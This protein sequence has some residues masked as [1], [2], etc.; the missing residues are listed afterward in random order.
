MKKLSA[1]I[2]LMMAF[3]SAFAEGICPPANVDAAYGPFNY[4]D[5]IARANRLPI[6]QKFHFTPNVENLIKGESSSLGGDLDYVLRSF[7]N[8]HRALNSL[9]RLALKQKRNQ[10]ADMHFS[11]DC[12][13]D[14]AIGYVPDDA[15]VHLLY[16]NYLYGIKKYDQSLAQYL[17]A[18]KID[19]E[20]PNILYN[21][22]LLY[23]DQKDYDKALSYAKKAYAAGFPLQGLKQKLEKAGKWQ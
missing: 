10:I 22:G 2:I 17:D 23:F 8:H 13:F 5:P 6:V 21:A 1:G 4:N 15:I 9:V 16:G 14:R 19:P 20:N 3:S 12:Y 18:E 7:P 11:V